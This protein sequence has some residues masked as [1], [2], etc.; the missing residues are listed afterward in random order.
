VWEGQ[1]C[2]AVRDGTLRFLFKNIGSQFHGRGFKM[3]ANLMQ[4]CCPDTVSNASTSL[5]LL[6]HNVQGESES[7]LVYWSRFDGLTLKLAR[8]K[9]M[10]PSIFLVVLFLCALHGWYSIIVDQF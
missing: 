5:L 6:F 4:H 8:C 7:I 10:I 9:D 3:L 1:L 2:F